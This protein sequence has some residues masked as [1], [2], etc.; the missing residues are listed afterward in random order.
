MDENG[1]PRSGAIQA[2]RNTAILA[3]NGANLTSLPPRGDNRG[4]RLGAPPGPREGLSRPPTEHA[5]VG[6][7]PFL[8]L[9]SGPQAVEGDAMFDPLPE[10]PDLDQLR[11]RAKELR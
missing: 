3:I 9:R 10:R 5:C 8:G 1:A 2:F 4:W 11:P 6:D 7:G